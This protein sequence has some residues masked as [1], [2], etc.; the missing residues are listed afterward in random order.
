MQE[1][2]EQIEYQSAQAPSDM[3]LTL[4]R[5]VFSL[6]H[7]DGA[8][9]EEERDLIDQVMEIFSFTDTQRKK[10]AEDLQSAGNTLGL[11]QEIELPLYRSQFFR[12]AR[13]V[14]WC[15]GLLHENELAVIETIRKSLGDDVIDYA[16]D[17]RW[18]ARKPDLPM[19]ESAQSPEEEMMKHI[20][21]Q[22][23]SF[24][25]QQESEHS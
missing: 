11:F 15:D 7:V 25:E 17:L 22:M 12:L 23:I 9:S 19:G 4:W 2:L 16:S 1:L 5:A 20:I 21:Y 3:G 18:I 13:I 10:I 8:I 6:A 24:Y 14:I